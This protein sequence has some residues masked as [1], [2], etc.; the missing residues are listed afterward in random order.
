MC[1]NWMSL[2][3]MLSESLSPKIYIL[4][5]SSHLKFLE[6]ANLSRN[7]QMSSYW[8]LEVEIDGKNMRELVEMT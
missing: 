7:K 8:F 3:N 6:K 1:Y 2:K 5:G 4:C